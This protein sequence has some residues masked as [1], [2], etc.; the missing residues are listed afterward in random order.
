M[1]YNFINWIKTANWEGA[2]L[3]DVDTGKR[4]LSSGVMIWEEL[5]HRNYEVIPNG[6]K[7]GF[8]E[9][10]NKNFPYSKLQF[11]QLNERAS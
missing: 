8:V 3:E 9:R 2:L 11:N 1:T 6:N 10:W 7:G 5:P 4:F